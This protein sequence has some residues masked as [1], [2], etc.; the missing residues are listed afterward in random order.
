VL[1]ELTRLLKGNDV[2]AMVY[3]DSQVVLN[4]L[5]DPKKVGKGLFMPW[6]ERARLLL[7][8]ISARVRF[9]WIPRANNSDCDQL[10]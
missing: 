5:I 4:Q 2:T 7:A 1:E 3:G 10:S 9:E 8:P 6:I